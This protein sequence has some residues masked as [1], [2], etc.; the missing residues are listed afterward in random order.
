MFR[1]GTGFQIYGGSFY[2]VQ[3][4]DVNLHTH[5]HLTIQDRTLR[6]AVSQASLPSPP[7]LRVVDGSAKGYGCELSGVVRNT[8]HT[9]GRAPY[10]MASRRHISTSR[11]PSEHEDPPVSLASHSNTISSSPHRPSSGPSS[12]RVAESEDLVMSASTSHGARLP[13]HTDFSTL[14]SLDRPSS[15]PSDRMLSKSTPAGGIPKTSSGRDSPSQPL[16]GGTHI[17]AQN[18]NHIHRHGE[19]GIN[20]LHHAAAL[21]ALYDS[22]ES[23]PQPKCHPE[24]RTET[25]SYLYNWAIGSDP[26]FSMFWLYGPAGAGKSAIVQTL[27]R[28]L[29]DGGRL[30]GSFFFKRGHK[31][32]GNA[33]VLFATLAYQLLLESP[34]LKG[35]I[36]ACQV[37]NMFP[38]ALAVAASST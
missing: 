6:E 30:G 29:K 17:I 37:Q 15:H 36:S 34:A 33:Q 24:T 4:G 31:T 21:E 13:S 18:V 28:R 25:L 32:R 7:T 10:E 22:A 27:C 1:N 12:E 19:T 11:P 23:F 9:V 38:G 14:P 20:I 8:R 35:P 5:Q 3:S 16:P 26:A 2:D